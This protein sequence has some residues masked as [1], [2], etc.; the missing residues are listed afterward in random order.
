MTDVSPKNK[1]K[2]LQSI[3]D[4]ETKIPQVVSSIKEDTAM[5]AQLQAELKEAQVGRVE[6]KDAIAKA[7]AIREKDL[8]VRKHPNPNAPTKNS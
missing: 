8:K 4:A 1:K 6:A 3:S 7:S 2:A 5:K